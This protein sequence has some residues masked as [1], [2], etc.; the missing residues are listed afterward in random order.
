MGKLKR[1][2]IK[3]ELIHITGNFKLAV[4]LNQMI[5]WSERVRDFD[6]FIVEEKARN[7]IS[8]DVHLRN[9]WI[10]K[11]AE[12]LVEETMVN[13]SPKAMRDYLKKLVQM[14]FLDERDNPNYKWD[15]T[16]QYR[17]NLIKIQNALLSKGYSLEG[18]KIEISD[19]FKVSSNLQNV[20]RYEHEVKAIPEITTENTTK[21]N[22]K[23]KNKEIYENVINF[24]RENFN[25]K[26]TYEEERLL[27]WL[28]SH[29]FDEPIM[30]VELAMNIALSYRANNFS[31]VNKVLTNWK[32]KGVKTKKQAEIVIDQFN[33]K[34]ERSFKNERDSTIPKEPTSR[35][36]EDDEREI[37]NRR[38]KLYCESRES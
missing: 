30:L 29:S 12:E 4:V 10:Y 37:L 35:P 17:V 25:P 8:G 15:R 21:N 32:E 16:K 33:A 3:E 24:Y 14:G 27:N 38:R 2:V 1:A 36:A 13:V 18:Y 11:K 23:E 5:Y 22:I 31:Y 20:K 34:K 6:N 9:G 19:L 26:T 28:N 7:E